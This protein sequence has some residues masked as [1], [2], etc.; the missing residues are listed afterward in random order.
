MPGCSFGWGG[1][2][3]LRLEL[4]HLS[5]TESGNSF[6]VLLKRGTEHGQ[7]GHTEYSKSCPPLPTCPQGFQPRP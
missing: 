3:G 1:L 7:R 4:P 6:L 2:R 5:L